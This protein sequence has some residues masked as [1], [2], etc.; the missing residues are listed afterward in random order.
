MELA[1]LLLW[2]LARAIHRRYKIWAHK[3]IWQYLMNQISDLDHQEYMI[4]STSIRA[5]SCSAGYKK[6]SKDELCLGR[7]AGG[8]TTKIHA[9]VVY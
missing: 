2:R 6:D 1:P 4:D 7:S 5:H 8:F 3:R 9:L